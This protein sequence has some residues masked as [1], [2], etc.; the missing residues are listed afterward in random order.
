MN[1]QQQMAAAEE[2]MAATQAAEDVCADCGEE[3]P[4]GGWPFCASAA[5]PEGHARGVY[6]WRA[7]F[8][9]KLQGWTRRE[10]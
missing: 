9:M 5:N 1:E 7:R 3:V 4:I 6:A 8:G 2:E 10:R